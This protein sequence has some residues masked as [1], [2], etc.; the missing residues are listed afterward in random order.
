L[1]SNFCEFH[2]AFHR[3]EFGSFWPELRESDFDHIGSGLGAGFNINVP[4]NTYGNTDSD[5]MAAFLEVLMPVAYEFQPE[6]V[7]ISAG[8][9]PAIGC[10][11]GEQEVA[12]T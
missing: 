2:T 10:P 5:Y 3:Y 7:L 9:D 12:D 8:F 6:L 1:I 4:L 11:E